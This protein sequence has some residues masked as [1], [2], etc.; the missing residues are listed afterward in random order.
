MDPKGLPVAPWR[1]L[2]GLFAAVSL[3]TLVSLAPSPP[4]LLVDF[5]ASPRFGIH[6]STETQLLPASAP[7]NVLLFS[8]RKLFHKAQL[9]PLYCS[10]HL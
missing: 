5:F 2:V 4:F 6:F 9:K 10:A 8:A 7:S 1:M 3:V